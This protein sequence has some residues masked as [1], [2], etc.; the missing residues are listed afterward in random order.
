[1]GGLLVGLVLGI[2]EVSRG[3]PRMKQL[4]GII[5]VMGSLLLSGCG[6]DG[7]LWWA[8]TQGIAIDQTNHACSATQLRDGR[9]PPVTQGSQP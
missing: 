6:M 9:C 1:V 2:M 4:S 7:G 3:G 5:L 8:K